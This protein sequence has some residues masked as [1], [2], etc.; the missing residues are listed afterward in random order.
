MSKSS[1]ST[2][3]ECDEPLAGVGWDREFQCCKECAELFRNE[4]SFQDEIYD[5]GEEYE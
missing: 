3:P 1:R 2:C 5:D 4:Q